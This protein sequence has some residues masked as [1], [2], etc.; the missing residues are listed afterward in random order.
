MSWIGCD[1][2][3]QF[4]AVHPGIPVVRR[5]P[6]AGVRPAPYSELIE[7][8]HREPN[9]ITAFFVFTTVAFFAATVASVVDS[10]TSANSFA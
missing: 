3:G 4:P 9:M 10:V 1:G 7:T 8:T 2:C 6:L 5:I